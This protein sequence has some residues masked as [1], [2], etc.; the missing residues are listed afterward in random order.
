MRTSGLEVTVHGP[1]LILAE[2]TAA[3]RA[4][5][6]SLLVQMAAMQVEIDELK[7]QVK[8]LTPQNSSVPPSTQHRHARPTPK[9]TKSKKK[10]GG[11][12][13]HGRVI[14]ELVLVES[15]TGVMQG[16]HQLCLHMAAERSQ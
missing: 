12:K 13:G 14:R 16:P 2:M 1:G 11:Q 15:C 4:F 5:V 3:V 9:P 7:T 10:R 6:E 8:R